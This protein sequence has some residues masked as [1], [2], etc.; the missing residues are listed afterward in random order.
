MPDIADEAQSEEQLMIERG[1]TAIRA[2]FTSQSAVDC[3]QCGDPIP[4][5]RRQL[6]P[7]VKTCVECQQRSEFYR[8][9]GNVAHRESEA[10]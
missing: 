8:K 7:G 5:R 1:L 4:E 10:D 2:Q 3:Q 9:V 6:L